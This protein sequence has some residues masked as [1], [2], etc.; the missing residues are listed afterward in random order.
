MNLAFHFEDKLF[1]IHNFLPQDYYKHL[2]KVIVKGRRL[3]S[4]KTNLNSMWD[5]YDGH[6]DSSSLHRYDPNLLT[7]YETLLRSQR[8]VD[9]RTLK[10]VSHI[11]KYNLYENLSWHS[12]EYPEEESK[13]RLYAATFYLNRRW[14][15]NWGGELMFRSPTGSGF[16]PIQGNSLIIVKAGLEHRVN[17]CLKKNYSRFSIQTF[18]DV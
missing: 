12:D 3:I 11:R 17:P 10:I 9:L 4:E 18:M 8:F 15:Q 7:V 14:G 5:K 16:V 2:H 6:L 1:W 13:K